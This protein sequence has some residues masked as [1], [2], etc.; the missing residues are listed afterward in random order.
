MLGI[1]LQYKF[2]QISI[3]SERQTKRDQKI[4]KDCSQMLGISR[5]E[6]EEASYEQLTKIMKQKNIWNTEY[7]QNEVLIRTNLKLLLLKLIKFHKNKGNAIFP[8]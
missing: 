7:Q 1:C 3:P 8:K 6:I 2:I 4:E 5:E